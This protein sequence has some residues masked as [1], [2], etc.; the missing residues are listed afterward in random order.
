MQP[1][2]I[3]PGWG[4]SGPDHWQTCWERELPHA[5]RLEVPDWH[6]PHRDDWLRALDDAIRTAAAPPI[7]IA[8]S[9]G[10]LA[11][12]HWAASAGHPVRGALLVAPADVDRSGCPRSL[13]DFG[14]VPRAR[15]PFFARV[16]ASDD[17]PY[18]TLG[19][20]RQ[21]ATDW[22]A[23]LAVL[24]RAGHINSE[25]GFGPW[26]EGR[27]WIDAIAKLPVASAPGAA[28]SRRRLDAVGAPEPELA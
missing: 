20:A 10:C 13:S 9:L 6:A 11:V 4:G 8:H 27:V 15:L 16:V 3:V 1:H 18:A 5:T 17:D 2:L 7:L 14:P 21:M 22:G 28:G 19:R 26:R 12:A 23:Q 24:P 25:S